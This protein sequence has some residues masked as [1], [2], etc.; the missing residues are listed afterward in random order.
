V[1]QVLEIAEMVAE[2][3]LILFVCPLGET[4]GVQVEVLVVYLD[5][6]SEVGDV[7]DVFDVLPKIGGDF[8]RPWSSPDKQKLK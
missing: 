7:H 6:A 4:G 5:S 1:K 3:H 8:R 2:V